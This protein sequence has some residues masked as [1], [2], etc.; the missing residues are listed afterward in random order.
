MAVC[1][2]SR[3]LIKA[4]LNNQS[5]KE[6]QLLLCVRKPYSFS[7]SHIFHIVKFSDTEMFNFNSVENNDINVKKK[8]VKLRSAMKMK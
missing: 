8:Q 2:I 7:H 6:T 5:L 3:T 4:V 1:S